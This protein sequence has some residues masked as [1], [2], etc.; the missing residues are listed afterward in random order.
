[1]RTAPSL[2]AAVLTA[3]A[4]AAPAEAAAAPPPNDAYLMSI[5]VDALEFSA[6]ADTNEATTQ[7]DMWNPNS[8]GQP[9][10]GG[11]AEPTACKGVGFG[12]TVWYDLEP[13]V[14]GG[15]QIRATGFP[16][17]VAVYEFNPNNPRL[18]ALLDCSASASTEDVLL[19]VE[20][21]RHYTIQV[22]G[23]GGV[24]GLMALKVDFF[25]DRDADG[26]LDALDECRTVPGIERFAGCPPSLRGRVTGAIGFDSRSGGIRINRLDVDGVPRGARVRASCPGCGSQTIRVRRAGRVSLNRLVG[27]DVRAGRVVKVRVTMGRSGNGLYR[28]GATGVEFRWP[29]QSGGVGRRSTRC[30]DVR[31]AKVERCS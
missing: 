9:F 26:V 4:L 7:P 11:D 28:F 20:G 1:M 22:G 25:P 30:L 8:S 27:R 14:D 2:L 29:V 31:T 12:K 5:P 15:V 23:V 16:T 10:G 17:V 18:G 13:A 19:N 24:G 21:G 3:A 6:A